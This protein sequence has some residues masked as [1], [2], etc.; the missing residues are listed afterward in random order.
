MASLEEIY[1]PENVLQSKRYFGFRRRNIIEAIVITGL[2]VYGLIQI[3][4]VTR[5]KVIICVAVGIAV[6]LACC[7]GIKGFSPTEL[8]S[9]MI[10]DSKAGKE[11]HLRSVKYAE[12][13]PKFQVNEKGE[14]YAN[15]SY[16]EKTIGF[17]K[18]KIKEFKK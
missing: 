14:V 6:F 8:L 5:I 1:I 15:Q 7:A 12:K 2:T 9:L 18:E 17:V 11:Y 4:F 16:A 10:K 3:P 13:K